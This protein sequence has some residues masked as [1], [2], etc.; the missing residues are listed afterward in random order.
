MDTDAQMTAM[1][2]QKLIE[3]GEGARLQELLRAKLFECGWKDQLKAHCQ[4]V[5]K[6]KGVR[7][8]TAAEL[9][10]EVTPRARALVPDSVKEELLQ[11]ISTFLDRHASL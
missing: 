5:I 10:A 11:R 1:I 7:H 4:D 3:T 9:A 6:E 8:V 2:V